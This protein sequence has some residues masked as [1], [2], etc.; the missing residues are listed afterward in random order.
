MGEFERHLR[1]AIRI[2]RARA[3]WYARVAGWQ[4]RL[5]SWWLIAS[6][7]LC[8]PLARYF[9]RRALPFNRR[10]IGVVQRDFVPMDVPDQTTPPPAVRPLTGAV[11]RSALRRLTTYRKRARHA[12]TQA[13]FD[14][15]ADLTRQML[16][17]IGQIEADAGTSLAM[18]RHLLES[19]GLC[20][21]NAVMY[22]AQDDSVQNLCHRLVAI[23]L[24][25]VGNGPWM[26]SL[27]SRCQ[28]RGAGILLN[29]V[30]AIPFPP[31]DTSAGS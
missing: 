9:D 12:L 15:V 8:L 31:C 3:A 17:D 1:D 7:Y 13:R 5:L 10:G 14:A 23:Q 24:A 4:A 2:N 25:L 16:R 28:S 26:D 29:D 22:I 6:E 27:G 20:S 11:R 19:I 18:T 21:H 30:P